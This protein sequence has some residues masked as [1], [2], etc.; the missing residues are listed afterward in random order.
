MIVNDYNLNKAFTILV[1]AQDDDW[2]TA[3]KIK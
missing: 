3:G 1:N 2:F